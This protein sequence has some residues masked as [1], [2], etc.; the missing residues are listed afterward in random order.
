ML[1]KDS[2]FLTVSCSGNFIDSDEQ[3][4][5]RP[6]GGRKRTCPT[7]EM[8]IRKRVTPPQMDTMMDPGPTLGCMR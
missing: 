8:L 6:R 3:F 1:D 7:V 2:W 5:S 4:Q